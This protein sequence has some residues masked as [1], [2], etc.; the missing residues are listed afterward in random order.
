MSLI[1]GLML[2]ILFAII[3]SIKLFHKHNFELIL[4]P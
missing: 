2:E 4:S 3:Y 1:K